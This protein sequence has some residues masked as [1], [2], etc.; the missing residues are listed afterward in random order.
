MP[1]EGGN[2]VQTLGAAVLGRVMAEDV[3]V[4]DSKE[5]L[6]PMLSKHL[7]PPKYPLHMTFHLF[8]YLK[9]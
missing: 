8:L 7:L 5:V 3:M 6:L 4:P 2:I 9:I 1:I